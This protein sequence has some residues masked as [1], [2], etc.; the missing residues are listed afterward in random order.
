ML[1]AEIRLWH[2]NE[3]R[4]YM[5]T[6]VE[7]LALDNCKAKVDMPVYH[8]AVAG[9]HFFDNHLVEQHFRVVFNDYILLDTLDL[10]AHAPSV[11]AD[12]KAAAPF[13]TPKLRRLLSR[14]APTK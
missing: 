6:T 11:I 1:E 5:H 10:Q 2:D 13:V 7:F 12:A 9:D 3:V 4:T 14:P 8:V